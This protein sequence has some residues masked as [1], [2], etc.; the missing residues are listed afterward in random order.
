[1][2]ITVDIPEKPQDRY[3][4]A[5]RLLHAIAFL[6]VIGGYW[7]LPWPWWGIMIGVC[8]TVAFALLPRRA[9]D[10]PAD[11]MDAAF[12]L[13]A[14]RSPDSSRASGGR[15]TTRSG[16]MLAQSISRLE[17]SVRWYSQPWRSASATNSGTGAIRFSC[18]NSCDRDP[19]RLR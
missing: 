18:G 15:S 1:M 5:R 7:W 3:A 6:L 19:T 13:V 12:G 8:E 17:L 4:R 11:G 10:E 9:E 2:V 16:K 14:E